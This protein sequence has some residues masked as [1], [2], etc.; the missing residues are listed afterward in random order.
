[1][2]KMAD[3][4]RRK[5]LQVPVRIKSHHFFLFLT[6]VLSLMIYFFKN[7]RTVISSEEVKPEPKILNKNI[8]SARG[9][10]ENN[11]NPI[12]QNNSNIS[13]EYSQEKM[14]KTKQDAEEIDTNVPKNDT[15]NQMLEES[16]QNIFFD[17]TTERH[18]ADFQKDLTDVLELPPNGRSKYSPILRSLQ[19]TYRGTLVSHN[20]VNSDQYQ[21]F[22]SFRYNSEGSLGD[23][24]Y[25]FVI[26]N[27]RNEIVSDSQ[28]YGDFSEDISYRYKH[29][30]FMINPQKDEKFAFK[31]YDEESL[32]GLFYRN[33]N[34]I[35][36]LAG[37]LF[38]NKV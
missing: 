21:V 38:L 11:S 27:D 3:R 37:K 35:S 9:E 7:T 1:M 36:K 2:L 12:F 20:K 16:P 5:E 22:L 19:G 24:S 34:G 17:A 4:L 28:G 33:E 25:R 31:F 32:I 6:L 8:S 18:L 30:F 13:P 23:G 14:V 15:E 29:K 26:I 10:Q